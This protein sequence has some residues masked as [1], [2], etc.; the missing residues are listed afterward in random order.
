MGSWDRGGCVRG[1]I[2]GSFPGSW[3]RGGVAKVQQF[4]DCKFPFQ[5]RQDAPQNNPCHYTFPDTKT[6]APQTTT[7]FPNCGTEIKKRGEEK[8]SY[9]LL[10][11]A[12]WRKTARANPNDQSCA[13][14][15]WKRI[16]T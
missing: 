15:Y 11:V 14:A 5:R 10:A 8:K 9:G 3:D 12:C 1:W 2:V 13:V 4:G 7:N 6:Q 16:M